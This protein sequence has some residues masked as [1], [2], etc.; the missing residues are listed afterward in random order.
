[1][2]FVFLD[3]DG[4]DFGPEPWRYEPH[5]PT[6]VTR[7]TRSSPVLPP[8]RRHHMQ[9]E[10]SI[11]F[12][13]K[14]D[15]CILGAWRRERA[16]WCLVSR[17]ALQRWSQAGAIEGLRKLASG[18]LDASGCLAASQNLAVGSVIT[19][20]EHKRYNDGLWLGEHRYPGSSSGP[21]I[22]TGREQIRKDSR[23]RM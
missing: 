20:V 3:V 13:K 5:Q 14:P 15:R 7:F 10:L 8:I 21:E 19:V 1:M 6:T 17:V 22:V 9:H 12:P 16:C 18:Q 2:Y 11:R 4:G 23:V